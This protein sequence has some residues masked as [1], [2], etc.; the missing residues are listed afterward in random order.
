MLDHAPS[1]GQLNYVLACVEINKKPFFYDATSKMS[2]PNLIRPAAFNYFGYL[3]TDKEAKKLEILPPN[4][5]NTILNI[6]AKLSKDGF[7]SGHF[8]DTDTDLYAMLNQEE[9]NKGKAEYQTT[10]YK[11]RYAFPL[12][13]IKSEVINDFD[14]QTSFDFDSDTFVDGIGNKFVFNPLL[15]LYSKNHDFDQADERKSPIELLTGYNK[16]KKVTITLP[17]GYAYENVPTSKKFRT[18]DNAIGYLYKVTQE[19]N[20]LI[21]ESTVTVED[22]VFPKEYYPAFKQIFDNITKFESQVVTVVKK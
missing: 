19:G 11:A 10:N 18:D 4:K 7:F 22:P 8:S 21:I 3:M 12:S 20:K 2:T 14:F 9:Y 16:L 5:S 13:N 17:D 15:F 6:D 1:R